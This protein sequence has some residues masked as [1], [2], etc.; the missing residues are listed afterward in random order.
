VTAHAV[1]RVN[2][3]APR[4]AFLDAPLLILWFMT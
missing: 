2:P 1:M 4:L 3:L